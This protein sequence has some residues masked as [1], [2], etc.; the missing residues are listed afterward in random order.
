MRRSTLLAT[1]AL[2][3]ACS[4]APQHATAPSLVMT[5]LS[6]LLASDPELIDSVGTWS[7]A[8]PAL[9]ADARWRTVVF[10]SSTARCAESRDH[11][12]VDHSDLVVRDTLLVYKKS[13]HDCGC[14]QLDARQVFADSR[15]VDVFGTTLT[16]AESC[17]APPL[18]V[19][20][21]PTPCELRPDTCGPSGPPAA[22]MPQPPTPA[23]PRC[24]RI[25]VEPFC[26]GESYPL[27]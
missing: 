12:L 14:V 10:F 1:F 8:L 3:A 18:V 6:A 4:A 11:A 15:E 9:P 22:P 13:A 26:P 19:A 2:S 17:K 16:Y 27:N 5:G 7:H 20:A 24:T 25:S 21:P 23:P